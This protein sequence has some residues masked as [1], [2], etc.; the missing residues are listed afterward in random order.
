MSPL[1][2]LSVSLSHLSSETICIVWP[3]NGRLVP[4]EWRKKQRAGG[5]G[6]RWGCVER[7]MLQL[8]GDKTTELHLT[9]GCVEGGCSG[10]A[11]WA[12]WAAHSGIVIEG[13]GCCWD[14]AD[15]VCRNG[16]FLQNPPYSPSPREAL[17]E[18]TPV[19]VW[20]IFFFSTEVVKTTKT[21]CRSQFH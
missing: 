2:P 20:R 6:G 17:T 13:G 10:G 14:A 19:A 9:C 4:A 7:E 3:K 15:K 18:N 16:S 5:V 1:Q 8:W 11:H 12:V 21:H